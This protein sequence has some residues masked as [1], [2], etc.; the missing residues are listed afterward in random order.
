MAKDSP[1]LAVVRAWAEKFAKTVRSCYAVAP[2]YRFHPVRQW[3]FDLAWPA[4]YVAF[5]CEG[6]VWSG[7]R[8]GTGTGFTDDCV[9]YSTAATLGWCVIR[10]TVQ[11]INKGLAVP[12]IEAALAARWKAFGGDVICHKTQ[13]TPTATPA[14][15]AVTPRRTSAAGPASRKRKT[16]K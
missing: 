6:G 13:A 16:V 3:R 8:H 11:Q 15:T 5:E 9:K 1:A 10:A 14:S 2:E 4:L 7:G 12:W